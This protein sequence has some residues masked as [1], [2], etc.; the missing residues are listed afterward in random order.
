M[1]IGSHI[2]INRTPNIDCYWLG[3]VPNL[4]RMDD[5]AGGVPAVLRGQ[6]EAASWA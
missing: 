1:I 4:N 5:E 3:A 2:A 6:A